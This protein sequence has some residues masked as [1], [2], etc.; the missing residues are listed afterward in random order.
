MNK[1]R[2]RLCH[3]TRCAQADTVRYSS[4]VTSPSNVDA[5][6]Q[7][8]ESANRLQAEHLRDMLLAQCEQLDTDLATYGSALRPV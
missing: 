7:T 2:W 5:G 6:D 8:P 4:P 3:S 1:K